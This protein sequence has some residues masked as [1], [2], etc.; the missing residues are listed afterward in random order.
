MSQKKAQLL[1]PLNGNL[2][3]T[4]VVTASSFVGGLTGDVT[5]DVTG[6]ASTATLANTATVA[7]NAQGLTGTPNIVVGSV[8]AASGS[9]SGNVSVGGTLSYQDVENIDSIGIITAQQGIQVL[10][11][12]LDIT[13]VSTFKSSVSIAD[14]IFHT[15]DTDTAVRF[16]SANTVT[17][18]T[19][20][21]EAIRV[22]AGRRLLVGTDSS[23][24]YGGDT[25]IFQI[26]GTTNASMALKRSTDNATE[27]SIVLAKSRGSADSPTV[28]NSNDILGGVRFAGYDGSDYVTQGASILCAVDG[29]PGSNDLPGRLVFNTTADGASTPSE[30]VRITSSGNVGVGENSPQQRLHVSSTASTYIQVQNTGDSVNAYYGVDT[31]GAWAG[32]STN[33]PFKLHTN[34]TERL[35]IT[36]TGGVHFNNGELIER[37][38]VTAGKLSDNTNIDLEDGMASL[39]TT[40]ETTTATP[41]IRVNSSTSLN[42]VMATGDVISV[43]IITTAAAAGYAATVHI[44]GVTVGTNGGSLVWNGGSA[45][46]EGGSSGNDFY[47]YSIIKTA[48]ATYTVLANVANFA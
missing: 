20:G 7:T 43:N 5:G 47:S 19:A 15:G 42:S 48:S 2:N 46:S 34:N 24:N 31:A 6:T 32:S 17:V 25:G 33:H 16:P 45:P 27:P 11:N 38:N 40:T 8:T 30:R 21:G 10:A 26:N 18:E 41:N 28:V 23:A 36:S 14:S 35:R 1:N 39:F 37:I 3:V 44:D 12:G 4:G 9:F 22:D 29:T 13:G